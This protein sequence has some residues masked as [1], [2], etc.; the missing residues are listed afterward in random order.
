MRQQAR[1]HR[2]ALRSGVVGCCLIASAW[3][4]SLVT[5]I[6]Y[7]TDVREV[8]AGPAYG[9]F[10]YQANLC[11]GQVALTRFPIMMVEVGPE[12]TPAQQEEARARF[13][14]EWRSKVKA[15]RTR[16]DRKHRVSTD[17]AES[18]NAMLW[19]MA[20]AHGWLHR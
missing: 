4:L 18:H 14:R 6:Q 17:G 11:L 15:P 2:F 13:F 9:F 1:R 20:A 5:V 7:V 16:H 12:A 8:D 10:Y 3:A 19:R